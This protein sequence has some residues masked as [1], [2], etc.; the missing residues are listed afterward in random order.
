MFSFPRMGDDDTVAK[1]KVW[2]KLFSDLARLSSGCLHF[3]ETS[4]RLKRA[5]AFRPWRW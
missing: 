3:N 4:A 2:R 5:N 1:R